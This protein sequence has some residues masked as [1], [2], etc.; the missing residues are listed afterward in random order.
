MI[1]AA[2]IVVPLSMSVNSLANSHVPF[3]LPFIPSPS[4]NFHLLSSYII[5][6]SDYGAALHWVREREPEGKWMVEVFLR[7]IVICFTL[8][9]NFLPIK[10]M[11]TA[12][13]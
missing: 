13:G 12:G 5:L 3:A 8:G 7:P 11:F 1:C 10:R 4:I 6:P 2:F 9:L